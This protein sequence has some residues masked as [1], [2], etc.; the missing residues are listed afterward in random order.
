MSCPAQ[1]WDRHNG[2]ARCRRSRRRAAPRVSPEPARRRRRRLTPCPSACAHAA[3]SCASSCTSMWSIWD[4]MLHSSQS[5]SPSGCIRVRV[6]PANTGSP[7]L[8]HTRRSFDPDH[9]CRPEHRAGWRQRLGKAT[10]EMSRAVPGS[11]IARVVG[12]RGRNRMPFPAARRTDRRAEY[13]GNEYCRSASSDVG[14]ESS[15]KGGVRL[16]MDP[17]SSASSRDSVSPWITRS[18][19]ASRNVASL[20]LPVATAITRTPAVNAA[21]TSLGVSPINTV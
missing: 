4:T 8:D 11:L 3:A 15:V 6:E 13:D 5:T 18:A 14:W 21:C 20:L 16:W 17:Y 9:E 1:C 2:C 10:P 7:L 19:P 12:D